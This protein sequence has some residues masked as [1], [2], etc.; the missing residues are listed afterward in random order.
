MPPQDPEKL[1]SLEELYGHPANIDLWVGSLLEPQV[2][3]WA[4]R[5]R[6]RSLIP[7]IMVSIPPSPMRIHYTIYIHRRRI[8]TE[9]EAKV[10]AVVWGTYLNAALAI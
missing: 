1:A 7:E 2:H 10:V 4:K 3:S 8:Y 9:E 6:S 5:R